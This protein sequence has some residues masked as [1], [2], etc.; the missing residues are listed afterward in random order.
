MAGFTGL[1]YSV[2][3]FP[4]QTPSQRSMY[5]TAETLRVVLL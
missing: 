5:L 2:L 4:D 3:G 1:F